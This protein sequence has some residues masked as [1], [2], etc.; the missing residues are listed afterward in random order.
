MGKDNKLKNY[1]DILEVTQAASSSVIRAA[2]RVLIQRYHPD[3]NVNSINQNDMREKFL[4]IREAYDVLS[5]ETRRSE[6]DKLIS[7]YIDNT[8][9]SGDKENSKDT[10]LTRTQ[11]KTPVNIRWDGSSSLGTV[12]IATSIFFICIFIIY[13]NSETVN[14]DNI[15]IPT[16]SSTVLVSVPVAAPHISEI[17][18]EAQI[19]E[20]AQKEAAVK[21]AR[22][23]LL[24][25]KDIKITMPPSE[26]GYSFCNTMGEVCNHFISIPE[27]S[28]VIYEN[29]AESIINH[30]NSNKNLIIGEIKRK[31]AEKKYTDFTSIDGE[32]ML[33]KFL[34]LTINTM[35]VG[36]TYGK[37]DAAK[38]VEEV[39]FPKS[40]KVI[41]KK[42]H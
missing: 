16:S 27:V 33:S 20:Q 26:G 23:I 10:D 15:R 3:K 2:Y 41:D 22:T 9:N 30:I 17:P 24:F 34:K 21:A 42:H 29:E 35:I 40:F 11:P 14:R 31:L 25:V 39:L 8:E 32:Q 19:I 13:I 38:G 12:F 6:Y 5:D 28:L 37:Y 7:N 4:L 36:H 18:T 1:Y